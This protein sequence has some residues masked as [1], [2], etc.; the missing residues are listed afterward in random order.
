MNKLLISGAVAVFGFIGK[1]IWDEEKAQ[2]EKRKTENEEH[3]RKIEAI[4][5]EG[6]KS[7]EIELIISKKMEAFRLDAIQAETD[8]I[9]LYSKIITSSNNSIK[10]FHVTKH[11]RMVSVT[12]ETYKSVAERKFLL[13]VEEAGGNGVLNMQV[14]PHRGGYFSVQGDAV[15]I[16]P[17]SSEKA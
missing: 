3:E 9:Q 4:K 7:V 6:A 14:R 10:G 17:I 16:E 12:D 13:A 11:I 15:L 8:C 2:Q 5:A 1:L